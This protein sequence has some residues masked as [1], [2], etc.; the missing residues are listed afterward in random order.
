VG[1]EVG[2][3]DTVGENTDVVGFAVVV[4]ENTDV[5]DSEGVGVGF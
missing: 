2:F 5:G 1:P 4:G 3:A